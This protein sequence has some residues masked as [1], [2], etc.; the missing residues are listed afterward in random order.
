[1]RA[2]YWSSKDF[3][4]GYRVYLPQED[5]TL[6]FQYAENWDAN[7]DVIAEIVAT[8]HIRLIYVDSK[9]YLTFL[10]RL[11][12]KLSTKYSYEA[13]VKMEVINK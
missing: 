5:K 12:T 10:N 2:M 4:N 1:M 7:L 13:D 8:N 11:K 3:V 6:S 9:A